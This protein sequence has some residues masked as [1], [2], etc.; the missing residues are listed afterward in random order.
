MSAQVQSHSLL[1]HTKAYKIVL[2]HT[3]GITPSA[4]IQ[5]IFTT[6]NKWSTPG[7]HTVSNKLVSSLDTNYKC[8]DGQCTP[9][10]YSS[11]IRHVHAYCTSATWQHVLVEIMTT[12]QNIGTCEMQQWIGNEQSIVYNSLLCMHKHYVMYKKSC[13]HTHTYIP[14]N[15]FFHISNEVQ[16]Q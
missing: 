4:W 13:A 8:R 7:L 15:T 1:H 11:P 12:A 14:L 5:Q 16:W 3:T 9:M 2:W 6:L 10:F